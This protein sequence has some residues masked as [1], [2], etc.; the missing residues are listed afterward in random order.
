MP[1]PRQRTQAIRLLSGLG[2]AGELRD[3]RGD[4]G[5]PDE[6]DRKPRRLLL[7]VTGQVSHGAAKVISGIVP[8]GGP[9]LY[10]HDAEDEVV[11]VSRR[12]VGLRGW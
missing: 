11:I 4:G 5:A 3:G 6:E 9:P 7:N 12:S 8:S 2:S 1:L 10:V